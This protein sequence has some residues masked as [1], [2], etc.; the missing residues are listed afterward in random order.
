MAEKVTD[1][2]SV[3]AVAQY[4]VIASDYVKAVTAEKLWMHTTI[5]TFKNYV[6]NGEEDVFKGAAVLDLA[7]GCGIYARW[8]AF[9]GASRVVGVDI[10]E[11]Q[12]A[13]ATGDQW[14]H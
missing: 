13:R 4:S 2:E 6:T 10:S 1:D 7:C 3:N 8:A 12:I 9:Q 14:L 11:E 5:Y